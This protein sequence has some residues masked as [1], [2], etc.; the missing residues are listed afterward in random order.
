MAFFEN[1]F[2][3]GIFIYRFKSGRILRKILGQ[4][5]NRGSDR[6]FFWSDFSDFFPDR[7]KS[8]FRFQIFCTSLVYTMIITKI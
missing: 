3:L 4:F 1:R 7:I 8:N 6:I 2:Y 5:K